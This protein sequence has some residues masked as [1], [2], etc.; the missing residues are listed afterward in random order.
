MPLTEATRKYFASLKELIDKA[1]PKP[2]EDTSIGEYRSS[3]LAMIKPLAIDPAPVKCSNMK[4]LGYDGNTIEMKIFDGSSENSSSTLIFYPGGGFVADLGVHTAPCSW[5]AKKGNCKVIIPYCR[6]APENKY[7]KGLY[8]AY[9]VY[10]YVCAHSVELGVNLEALAVGGD[11]SGGNF[12][13]F[14][15]IKARNEHL[16]L[17]H[18]FLV[19]P[20]VDLSRSITG[21][22]EFEREDLLLQPALARWAY[23]QYLPKGIDPKNPNVSP[24]FVRNLSNLAPATIIVGEYDGFRADAEGYSHK[25]I[26]A[27]TSCE[28]K[29][30]YGQVHSFLIARRVL[31]DGIDPVDIIAEKM[32]NPPKGSSLLN[33]HC[34]YIP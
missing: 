24:Y 32:R 10:D 14:I 5:I 28:L 29:I 22:E 8:D 1:P 25:L 27:G 20:A 19:S 9:A 15:A 12:A 26:G 34:N 16:P 18:Q 33:I 11:S 7:P 4:I 30:C 6:L 23:N 3:A 31:Y 17:S 13:A 21:F 2:L